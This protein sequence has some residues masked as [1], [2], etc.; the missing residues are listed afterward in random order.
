MS[1][2]TVTIRFLPIILAVVFSSF[3]LWLL[4]SWVK[5]PL[6]IL[7]IIAVIIVY[8]LSVNSSNFKFVLKEKV[9]IPL[10]INSLISIFL[11][12]SAI[13]LLLL[14]YLGIQAS[15]IQLILALLITSVLPG[16]LLL[17]IF[18]FYKY[19][20]KLETIVLSYLISFIFTGL[21]TLGLLLI[22]DGLRVYLASIIYLIIGFYS[23]FKEQKNVETKLPFILLH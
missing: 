4:D 10:K 9:N 19:F 1:I 13:I 20:S 16:Y 2:K 21:M 23:L 17:R 5:V 6:F 12:M 7:E 11:I 18:G 14:Y 8:F 3:T 22:T 15:L